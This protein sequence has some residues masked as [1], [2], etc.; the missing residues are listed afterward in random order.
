ML[1]VTAVFFGVV[2]RMQGS[3]Y[4]VAVVNFVSISNKSEAYREFLI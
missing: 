2:L 1:M 3:I 4:R